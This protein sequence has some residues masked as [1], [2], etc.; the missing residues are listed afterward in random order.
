MPELPE[1]ETIK[2]GLEPLILNKVIREVKVDETTRKA[3][4]GD[5]GDV[6]DAKVVGLRRRGKAL[7][8]DLSN[9]YTMLIHLR[10]TGQLIWRDD[11][12]SLRTTSSD[13]PVRGYRI[14]NTAPL[15]ASNLPSISSEI[16]ASSS[17]EHGSF[18]DSKSSRSS[19]KNTASPSEITSSGTM[20]S[21]G[22]SDLHISSK[23]IASLSGVEDEEME[24]CRDEVQDEYDEMMAHQFAAGH[25]S[26]NFMAELPNGQ[27]RVTFVFDDGTLY[28]ND[29]RKFGFVKVISTTEVEKEKFIAE[30]AKEPWEM[31][32]QELFSQCQRHKNSPIKAVLLDQKVIAGL[33][34]IYADESL[35]YASVHPAKRAGELTERQVE[36]IL[37]GAKNVMLAS[38]DSGGSTMATYVKPDGSTGSY[39]ENFAQVFR[40]EGKR[41]LRCGE[42][43]QKCRV[44]GRGTHYCPCC[45]EVPECFTEGKDGGNGAD[46][47]NKKGKNRGKLKNSGRDNPSKK[48]AARGVRKA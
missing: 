44:A 10:M 41:C 24:E 33:G 21:K 23:N 20:S 18:R 26:K 6:V 11:L 4:Q 34:N 12:F 1:V 32:A 46:F 22:E 45:Q 47:E 7:L 17:T 28:F 13:S 40:R 15:R 42:I 8:V 43:I 29:Q 27:T 5:E 37:E 25:P 19:S 14:S 36:R 35:F 31:S 16:T 2:R 9:G 38:I 39:L 3:F 30:L 48:V